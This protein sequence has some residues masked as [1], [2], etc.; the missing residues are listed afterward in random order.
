MAKKKVATSNGR[1]PGQTQ[2]SISLPVELIAE[3]DKL[4]KAENRNRSNYITT[5][6]ERVC[7]AALKKG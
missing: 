6:L 4:A 3:I 1:A 5:H 7:D 2:I